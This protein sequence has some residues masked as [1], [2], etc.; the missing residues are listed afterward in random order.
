[1]SPEASLMAPQTEAQAEHVEVVPHPDERA[2]KDVDESHIEEDG[3]EPKTTQE[4]KQNGIQSRTG[5]EAS[6][7]D[8]LPPKSSP[9]GNA[10]ELEP[11]DHTPQASIDDENNGDISLAASPRLDG[12]PVPGPSSH[13]R[14]DSVP[15]QKYDVS[16]HA[17]TGLSSSLAATSLHSAIE[18]EE[19]ADMSLP[20]H[21]EI[22]ERPLSPRSP[23]D[24]PASLQRRSSSPHG[25]PESLLTIDDIDNADLNFVDITLDAPSEHAHLSGNLLEPSH[26]LAGSA[27]T[28]EQIRRDSVSSQK[29][30]ASSTPTPPTKQDRSPSSQ[31]DAHCSTHD[32]STP[33]SPEHDGRRSADN[34]ARKTNLKG[35]YRGRKSA[36]TSRAVSPSHSRSPSPA[37]PSTSKAPTPSVVPQNGSSTV[38]TPVLLAADEHG[39]ISVVSDVPVSPR[40]FAPAQLEEQ[41]QHHGQSS[42]PVDEQRDSPS[43]RPAETSPPCDAS[44]QTQETQPTQKSVLPRIHRAATSLSEEVEAVETAEGSKPTLSEKSADMNSSLS[45]PIANSDPSSS[46]TPPGLFDKADQVDATARRKSSSAA[47][48]EPV[49]SRTRMTT[50]PAKTKTEEIKHRADFERMMM[51]AKEAERKKREEEEERKRRRQDE[52]HEALARWEKEILPSWSRA[53]KDPE[54]A[55]LWWKG[56]P[57]SIR[58]R[59]WALAIGNPLMLARNLLEQAEKKAAGT[60]NRSIEQ[61]IPPRVLAQ[62]DDD[63]E[64]S[65]PRLKL[66]QVHGP[67]HEDLVRL[68]RAFVLVRMEQLAELDDAGDADKA[69]SHHQSSSPLSRR[70]ELPALSGAVKA[71]ATSNPR[72]DVAAERENFEDEY[73]KRGIDIYQPGLA[74]LAAVL[75]INMSINTA[76]IA[77]LNLLHTKSWLKALYSLLPT[78][79]P[80]SPAASTNPTAKSASLAGAATRKAGAGSA[81]TLPPKEKEIRGFERVLETLLADQMPKVYANLLAHNVKLY[82]VIL[83]DWVST[84]WSR[85]L[86]VDTVMRLWDVVL[87][88][89][90]DSMIYR[91]CLGLVQTLESRLYVPDQEEL[92]SVFRG[93]NKAALAIWRREKEASGE[94]KMHVQ[95]ALAAPRHSR[96]STSS[97]APKESSERGEPATRASFSTAD[98]PSDDGPPSKTTATPPRSSSLAPPPTS[99][100]SESH[101]AQAQAQ[102]DDSSAIDLESV[103]PRDYIYE[104]YGIQEHHM[105]ETLEAQDAWWK[106]ST[107]QRLLDRELSE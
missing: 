102:A 17:T 25:N 63:V 15:P 79:L 41:A 22:A 7:S 13:R 26:P 69:A 5:R 99:E 47:S 68:C 18:E 55:R 48:N 19:E 75:L 12:T 54:L 59:V 29:A 72:E 103:V 44:A 32:L 106:Q 80:S 98:R 36:A 46:S 67:L 60:S 42:R 84:L 40:S 58:G 88:D 16:E 71:D 97:S 39:N 50:L 52:Q 87:L 100:P 85:W 45:V 53:R 95:R 65:L 107:L 73:A 2:S 104:Q 21:D 86:D 62:I 27:R 10:I 96:S 81:Y 37:P 56:A 83:R 89:E 76:F 105:F 3:Y 20:Q 61:I 64:D 14:I 31:A 57:P 49:E 8:E 74:S 43:S 6:L 93:T 82:R 34:V 91:V 51:M 92:E 90:T 9:L 78:V 70:A 94:L 23:L 4:G 30:A 66:F 77:L 38:P 33:N 28:A 1:M 24:T 11:N 101:H 35:R